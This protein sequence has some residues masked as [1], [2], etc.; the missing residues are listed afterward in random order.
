MKYLYLIALLFLFALNTSA[1]NSSDSPQLTILKMKWEMKSRT[2]VESVFNP[3]PS[4]DPFQANKETSQANKDQK[5][6]LRDRRIR[7]KTN[8]PIIAPKTRIKS[9]ENDY[10]RE[11]FSTKYAY[12]VKVQNNGTKT[13]QKIVWEYVFVSPSS[14]QE[15]G[16]HEFENKTNLKP[17]ET[18]TLVKELMSPPTRS[19]NVSDAGK[20]SADLYIEQINIKSIDYADGTV[21]RAN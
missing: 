21:W 1:Q 6:Y 18:V 17:Q 3:E 15:I 2:D 4:D 9:P 14:K 20:K 16:R 13:I 19:I 11:D 5:D 12:Q 10:R 8:Q 7:E